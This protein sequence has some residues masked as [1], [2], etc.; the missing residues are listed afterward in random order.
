MHLFWASTLSQIEIFSAE[1][2][3]NFKTWSD[4]PDF[5][6]QAKVPIWR[7]YGKKA[8]AVYS[9]SLLKHNINKGIEFDLWAERCGAVDFEL[10]K[11]YE[12][13]YQKAC[14]GSA[15]G[16]VVSDRK[17]GQ[18]R[19]IA[20]QIK[21]QLEDS[22]LLAKLGYSAEGKFCNELFNI[23]NLTAVLCITCVPDG[24][25]LTLD[26]TDARS[27]HALFSHSFS[28]GLM[29]IDTYSLLTPQQLEAVSF[30]LQ[31]NIGCL[32][33]HLADPKGP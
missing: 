31:R 12:E 15:R 8:L 32:R 3:Q 5:F 4:L 33:E 26:F 19:K 22:G 20:L 9:A 27:E 29:Y 30:D 16:L 6:L 1:L 23:Q 2:A 21:Q 10:L 17:K 18:G 7:A 25:R 11:D 13:R 28:H 14:W 24:V